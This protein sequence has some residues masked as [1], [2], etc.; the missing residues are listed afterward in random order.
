LAAAMAQELEGGFELR[1]DVG[2]ARTPGPLL[3]P[4]FFLIGTTLKCRGLRL[5]RFFLLLALER[6]SLGGLFPFRLGVCLLPLQ[7]GGLGLFL[8]VRRTLERRGLRCL[9]FFFGRLSLDRG[10]FRLLRLAP[11]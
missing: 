5:L 1:R 8:F 10:L 2:P 3:H 9:R 4:L 6:G 7:R 11:G